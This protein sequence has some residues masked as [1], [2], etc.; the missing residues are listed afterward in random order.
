MVSLM[1]QYR[2]AGW[3]VYTDMQDILIPGVRIIPSVK[4]L[5]GCRCEPHSVLFL[6]E[7]GLS[8]NN[9]GYSQG[10][11]LSEDLQAFW[12]YLR[13]MES[14]CYMNSQAFDV[15]KKV[16]DT[17]DAMVLQVGIANLISLSRPIGRRITLTDANAA[18]GSTIADQLYFRSP[19]SWRIF[20]MPKYYKYFDSKEM[21]PRVSV[22]YREVVND[23]FVEPSLFNTIKELFCHVKTKC[24]RYFVRR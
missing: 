24:E 4:S 14:R 12:K 17:T 7:V 2:K 10:K 1:L 18:G 11:G 8:M 6:D 5:E 22:P 9:R 15:D 19:L 3:H 13:K 20:W 23:D 21:P 16:R